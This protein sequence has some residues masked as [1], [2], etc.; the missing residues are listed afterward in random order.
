MSSQEYRELQLAAVDA[1]T[2]LLRASE[3]GTGLYLHRTLACLRAEVELSY[4]PEPAAN[5]GAQTFDRPKRLTPV[6]RERLVLEE[7]G[8]D[9]LTVGE[10]VHRIGTAYPHVHLS[11]GLVYM[12]LRALMNTGDVER[13]TESYRGQPR[14]RYSRRTK[15]EGPIVDLQRMFDEES[16]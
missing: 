10:L 15:L 7:L 2:D 1:L 14:H 11:R 3:P 12:T 8:D 4:A 5:T 9:R 16:A 13:A 6:E